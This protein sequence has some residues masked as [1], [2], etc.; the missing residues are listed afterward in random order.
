MLVSALQLHRPYQSKSC[1]HT[2]ISSCH[3]ETSDGERVIQNFLMKT[4]GRVAHLGSFAAT[5]CL[6]ASFPIAVSTVSKRKQNLKDSSFQHQDHD[7]GRAEWTQREFHAEPPSRPLDRS[8]D[9]PPFITLCIFCDR[10]LRFLVRRLQVASPVL[11]CRECT[12]GTHCSKLRVK[13][14]VKMQY[15]FHIPTLFTDAQY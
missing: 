4:M 7:A 2:R 12:L 11:L 8:C 3:R 10:W 15:G 1:S 9:Q 5:S 13:N 14:S 6:Y